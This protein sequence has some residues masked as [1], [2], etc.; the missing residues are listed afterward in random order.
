MNDRIIGIKAAK[1]MFELARRQRNGR[2]VERTEY[3]STLKG[4]SRAVKSHG[5]DP[6][7]TYE[8]I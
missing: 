2:Y 5:F 1:E 8:E 7:C 6:L 3:L 4:F